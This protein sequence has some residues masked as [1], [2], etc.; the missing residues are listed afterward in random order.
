VVDTSRT[1]YNKGRPYHTSWEGVIPIL[2]RRYNETSSPEMKE[3]YHRYMLVTPCPV[4][5]GARL[6]PEVLAVTV[7]GKNI[8]E[9][10]HL[11]SFLKAWN[12]RPPGRPLRRLSCGS[13]SPAC[14]S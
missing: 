6:R 1:R 12:S 13:C 4:C 8:Q 14:I 9:A 10:T 11:S 3:Y 5:K 2:E 7:G